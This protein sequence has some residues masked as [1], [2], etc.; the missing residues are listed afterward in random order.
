MTPQRHIVDFIFI[1]LLVALN[2]CGDLLMARA[3]RKVGDVDEL[4]R[5]SGILGVVRSVLTSPS[6]Y[7]ALTC[8]AL[9]FFSLLAALSRID[10]SIVIPATSSLNFLA[11]LLG[12]K[13]FLKEH[14][15]RRRWIAGLVVM[16]GVTLLAT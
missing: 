6:F 14:L 13:F 3:M 9:G 5:H 4:R 16:G 10:L 15:D 8:M 7:S 11:N 12:A 2:T 1:L